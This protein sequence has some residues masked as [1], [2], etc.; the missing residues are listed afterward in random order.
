MLILIRRARNQ[1]INARNQRPD[2]RT[3]KN[4]EPMHP[5][6]APQKRQELSHDKRNRS[7]EHHRKTAAIKVKQQSE[8]A[9]MTPEDEEQIRWIQ[10]PEHQKQIQLEKRVLRR[11]LLAAIIVLAWWCLS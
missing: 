5:P 11:I 10:S 2:R 6:Y 3:A 8:G 4:H 7:N 9:Q 1:P